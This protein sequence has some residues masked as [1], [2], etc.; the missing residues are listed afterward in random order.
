MAVAMT[1]VLTAC[2]AQQT[3]LVGPSNLVSSSASGAPAVASSLAVVGFTTLSAKGESGRLTA[4]VTY[5]DGSV[6]NRTT[7]AQWASSDQSVA[8]VDASG[9]V[10]ALRDGRTTVTA[11]FESIAGAKTIV[12]DLP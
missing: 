10:T 4:M 9:L 1:Y 7:A 12:V 5:T 11:T 3:S 8:T 2:S 6:Q